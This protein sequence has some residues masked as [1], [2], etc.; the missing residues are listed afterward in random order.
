M[1]MFKL[2][3]LAIVAAICANTSSLTHAQNAWEGTVNANWADSGNWSTGLPGL[4]DDVVF[5]TP[6]P[7]T[8]SVITLG[9]G[10]L[11]NSLWIHDNYT[12]TGGDLALASGGFRVN[13]GHLLTLDSILSGANGLTLTG[14]GMVRL[15]NAANDYT[16]VTTIA[17]GSLIISDP[18]QLGADSSAVVVQGSATR[19]FG[20][21]QLVLDGGYGA[22]MDLSRDLVL[23]G[24]GPIADRS[25]ALIS[26]GNNTLSGAITYATGNVATAFNSANGLLTLSG[27]VTSAGTS[28]LLRFGVVN[29]AGVGSYHFTGKLFNHSTGGIEKLGSGTLILEPSALMLNGTVLVNSGSLRVSNGAALGTNAANG[30]VTLGGGSG[31]LEVRT[32]LPG[33]FASRRVQMGTSANAVLFLDHAGG[34]Q[35]LN[36]TVQFAPLTLTAGTTTRTLTINSRNGYGVTF[37]GDSVGGNLGGNNIIAINATGL[38]TFDGNFWNN[39][40]GTARTLTMTVNTGAQAVI[41]GNLIAS[42]SDHILTK[43]GAGTLTILGDASTYTGVTNVNAGTLAIS[44]FGSIN[45]SATHATNSRVNIGSSGTAA[46]LN[47]IG[48]DLTLAQASTGKTINLAGSAGGATILANQTGSSPGLIFNANF[49]ATGA[50]VKTLTLGG[51]NTLDNTIN[52]VIPNNSG[53]NITSVLKTGPG[54]WVLG[55]ANIYTGVT[56]ISNGTLKVRANAAAST[57][58]HDSSAITFGVTGTAAGGT[59]EFVGQDSVNNVENLGALSVSAGANTL[60]LTPGAGGTASL[61]FSSLGTV[62]GAASLNIL[63]SD[64]SN[65]VTLTGVADGLVSPMV[66]FDNS[67]F[68]Y[69][70]SEVLR[71]AV[72]GTD[73]GFLTTAG[74]ANELSSIAHWEMTGDVTQTGDTNFRSL[75]IVDSSLSGTNLRVNAEG[76]PGSTGATTHGTVISTGNSSIS[77]AALHSAGSGALVLNVVDGTLTLNTLVHGNSTGGLTKTGEGTLVI[78]GVNNQTG[79]TTINQGTVQLAPGGRLSANTQ[80]FVIRQGATLD[81]NGVNVSQTATTSSIGVFNGEGTIT[82]TSAASAI[83]A[84]AGTGG[85]FNGTI[86]EVN[87][88][89]SVIKMGTTTTQVFNGLSNYTGSTTI[90]V[91]GN[92]TTGT[93]SAFYLADIGQDSSIG[94]GDATDTASNAAS[95]VFGGTTGGLIYTGE[96]SLST[97]RLFTLAGTVAGAGATITNNGINNAALVFSN[98]NPIAFTGSANQLLRL[99]GSSLADNWFNPQITNGNDSAVTSFTKLGAGLWILG[100]ENNTYTGVTTI[101]EGHLQAQDGSSLP[102][103]SA[104]L[105]GGAATTTTSAV[106]QSSGL[107]TRDLGTG[108]GQVSWGTTLTTGGAGFAASTDKLVVAI[109]GLGTETPLVWNTGGFLPTGTGVGTALV[110]SSTTALAEVE[111]RNA[112]DLNGADRRIIVNDN[113]STFTDFATLSGVISGT[114]GLVKTNTAGTLRLLGEN[115]YSG[116]TTITGGTLIVTSLGN[117][118][119]PGPS[120]VG[121]SAN[122]NTTGSAVL[123]GGAGAQGILQ[124]VGPGETSDRMIRL[125]TTSTSNLI[126]ADGTGPLILTNVVND[127]TVNAKTLNLR[128]SSTA[129]NMITSNLTDNTG[130]LSVTVDG[131]ATWILSGNNTYTGN[132]TISGG[133]L[134]IGSDNAIGATLVFNNGSVFAYGGDRTI[135][136]ALSQSSGTGTGFIGDYSLTFTSSLVSAQNSTTGWVTS[137]NIVAGK[138]LTF[139]AGVTAN[140][141]TAARAWTING[142]GDTII[143]GDITTST[144]FGLNITYS[145]NGSLLLNGGN[146]TGGTF[147]INNAAGRVIITGDNAFGTGNALLTTGTL[148]SAGGDRVIANN[149]THGGTFIIGGDDK[150]TFTGTW[151]N[152]AGSR[153]LNVA[154]LGGVELAGNVNLSEH[155]TT[156][157]T[158]TI[159]GAGDVLISGVVSNGTGTGASALSYTGSGVMTLTGANTY[160]GTTTLNNANGVLRLDGA[161]LLGGGNVTLTNGLLEILDTGVDQSIGG[162]LT[163]GASTSTYAE[164]SIG[165]GRT[166]TLD[167][168]GAS[169]L[170]YTASNA[171]TANP[172]AAII[173]GAGTLDLGAADKTITVADNLSAVVDLSWQMGELTGASTSTLIKAGAGTLDISGIGLNSFAGIYQIDAGTILGLDTLS[174]N[175]ALNGGVYTGNGVF[176]RALGTGD[177]QIQWLAGGGGFAA[178]G[179]NLTVTLGGAPD[180]LVWDDTAGFAP[181]G[182]PLIFGSTSSDGVVDFTHNIDLNDAARTVNVVNNLASEDDKT[183]LSGELSGGSLVKT[184]NG[185]L[186]LT[187]AGNS[188][189]G[190]TLNGNGGALQFSVL[191]NL[192]GSS[193][194]IALQAG[195]LSFIGDASLTV[196]NV[197]DATTGTASQS[198]GVRTL[199]ANGTDGAI[200]T[201]SS[202]INTGLNT[203]TLAGSGTGVLSG[204]V[205]QTGNTTADIAITSGN[206]TIRDGNITVSDDLLVN[207]GTLTLEDMVFTLNDDVVATGLGTVLNLNTTGVLAAISPAGTSTGLYSRN[208]ALINLNA[209]DV[210]GADNSGGLD[211]ILLGDSGTATAAGTLNMNAFNLTTPRLDLGGYNAGLEGAILGSGTLTLTGVDA[212]WGTGAR[213]WRGVIEANLAGN[214]TLWKLGAG[215]VTLSGDNSGLTGAGVNTRVDGGTLIL[216]YTTSNTGKIAANVALDQRGGHVRLLGNESAGTTQT[217]NGLLLNAGSSRI[218]LE[219]G[220][221]QDLT[222][223]LGGIT[224]N[225]NGAIHFVLSAN[226]VIETSMPDMDFLGGWAAVNNGFAS[227][228]GGQIVA[229]ATVAKDDLSTWAE[230]DNLTDLNGYFGTVGTLAVS[231][232]AFESANAST[233]TIGASDVLSL[234]NGGILVAEGAGPGV[235]TGGVLSSDLRIGTTAARNLVIHQHNTA[236]DFTISSTIDPRAAITKA[237]AGTLVLSGFNDLASRQLY[238]GDGTVRALGGNAIGDLSLVTLSTSTGMNGVLD[239]SDAT[240]TIGSLAGGAA[241]G[242]GFGSVLLGATGTLTLNSYASPT[243]NAFLSGGPDSTLIKNKGG[244]W[245]TNSIATGFTGQVIINGGGIRLDGNTTAQD[246]LAQARAFTI[247]GPGS[248]LISDQDQSA[249]MN[250]ISDTAA[251]TLANTVSTVPIAAAHGLILVNTQDGARA[252]TVGAVTLQAGYNSIFSN[253]GGGTNAARIGTLTLT[254][255]TRQNRSTLL[256]GGQNLGA[257][258]G[259][260]GRITVTGGTLANLGGVGGAGV[261]GT[262]TMS[263]IPYAVGTAAVTATT[264]ANLYLVTGNSLVTY[265]ATNGFRPLNL[266][267]E[268]VL[269]EAGYNGLAASSTNNVRFAANPA[270]AL[271]GGSKTIN[272]LVLDSS[273]GALTI[274]S[275]AAG[276]LMLTSGA[277]LATT[278]AAANGIT[279]NGFSELRTGTAEYLI[280]VTTAAN[281]LTIDAALTSGAALTKSGPGILALTNAANSYSGGTWLNQGL[282][283][284]SDPAALGYG[285]INFEG[286]GL[287]WAPGATFD[288]STWGRPLNFN[289]GGAVFDSN[290][291]D[292]IL[293]GPTGNGGSGGLTKIGNGTLTLMSA[294]VVDF[295]GSVTVAGGITPSS[296]LVYGVANA[297]PSTTDLALGI[298]SAL[299]GYFTHGAFETTLRGLNINANSVIAGEADLTFTGR[300]EVHGGASRTLTINNTGTTTFDGDFLVLVDRGGTARTLTITAGTDIASDITINSE[301]TDGATIAG[302]LAFTT[303]N[304]IIRLNGFNTHTGA[305]TL[306]PGALGT[307]IL[308]NDQALGLGTANFT[309]GTLLS[310]GGDL[311]IANNITHNG[312]FIIGGD[313][314]FTFTGTWLNSTGSR[315]LNVQTLAGIELAGNVFL[316]EHA[317]TARTLTITGPGDV[318]IS[319]QV[320]NGIGTG[321]SVLAYTGTGTLTLGGTVANT[322]SNTTLNNA[323]G[324]L[325]LMNPNNGGI[326]TNLFTVTNGSLQVID[327]DRTIATNITWT[328]GNIIG[329]DNLTISALTGSTGNNRV[330]TNNLASGAVLTFDGNLNINAEAVS[331]TLTIAGSG[332]T[333]ISGVIQNGTATTGGLIVTSTGLTIISGDANTYTGATTLGSTEVDAGI[334]RVMPGSSLGAAANLTIFSGM[335]D[336]LTAP[337]ITSLTMGNGPLG[338]TSTL[339]LN[340]H[341]L[342]LGGNVTYTASLNSGLALVTPGELTLNATRT[343]TINKSAQT[344]V[345]MIIEADISDG[346]AA[347]GF[348]KSGNGTLTLKGANSFTGL[349]TINAGG[350]VLDFTASNTNKLSPT[351][352]LTMPGS[353]LTLIGNDAAGSSQTVTG[354]TL[355]AGASRIILEH[356]AGQTVTLTLGDITRATLSGAVDFAFTPGSG[357]IQTSATHEGSILGGWATVNGS[358]F[359][360]I[361]AGQIVGFASTAKDDI[362]TWAA[363]DD[364]TDSAGYFGALGGPLTINSLRIGTASTVDLGGS[365]LTVASGGI[366]ISPDVGAGA[367][368]ITG[369]FLTGTGGTG[370]ELFVHQH[371]TAA[372]FEIAAQLAGTGTLAKSGAGVLELSG[373]NTH[374]GITYISEGTLSVT[375]EHGIGKYSQVAFKNSI[376]DLNNGTVWT[377]GLG[378][379]TG[380]SAS[381]GTTQLGG[382]VLIGSGTLIVNAAGGSRTFTGALV[383]DGT[384]IKTGASVQILQGDSIPFTGNVIINGGQL[385]LDA[386]TGGINQAATITINAAELLNEQDQSGSRD[387]I[388][389][390]TVV[391]LNN[392]A[393]SA[394][395]AAN[396]R[397]LWMQTLNQNANRADTIGT[398]RLGAGHNVIQSTNAA[399]ATGTAQVATMTITNFERDNFATA[400]L[401]GQ[402]LGAATGSRGRITTPLA[403]FELMGAVGGAYVVGNTD[404]NIIPYFIGAAGVASTMAEADLLLQH[405]NSFVTWVSAGEGFRPLNLTTEY[406]LNEA[407]YN[408]LAGVTQHNV[409]FAANPAAALTGGSKTI[410]SLVL[411]SSAGALTITGDAGDT[412]T[413]ASGALMATTTVAA[414]GITLGGFDALQTAT[415]E[416]LIYVTNVANKLT[417]DSPLTSSASLTKAG[418]GILALTNAANSYDGGTWFNQGLIEVSTLDALGTGDLHF[419]GGGL[420]W[421]TGATFD[422]SATARALTFNSGGAVFDTNG[423][424]VAVANAIGNGGSGG[425]TKLGEGTLTLNAPVDFSGSVRIIGGATATSALVYGVADALPAGTDLVLGNATAGQFPALGGYFDHAGFETTLGGLNVNVNSVI[426]GTADLT[427]TGDVEFHGSGNRTLTINNTGTTTFNGDLFTL[428]DR[429]GTARTTTITAGS[430]I[431]SD[432]TINSQIVDGT[433]TGNLSFTANNGIIT[434]N[435]RNTY[436]GATTINPGALGTVVISNDQAFGLG[437]ALTLASGTLQGDGSGTKTLNQNVTN[438]TGTITIGG[439]DGFVFNGNWLTSGGTR[440]LVANTT[441]GVV[442]NGTITLGETTNNR[443]QVFSGSGDILINGVIQNNAGAGTPAGAITYTGTGTLTLTGA[444]TY[445]GLTQINGGVLA[446]SHDGALGGTANGTVVNPGGTLALSNDIT[447]T[448]ESLALTAGTDATGHATLY[449]ADGSNTWTGDLTVDTGTGDAR[450]I[451]LA[452]SGSALEISGNIAIAN[453]AANRDIVFAGGG[454]VEIS[455]SITSDSS[456]TR[457]RLFMSGS[458]FYD[459]Y[460]Q[461]GTLILSGDNSGYY[462]RI[463]NNSQGA[464]LQ[465]S[466]EANLGAVPAT[467][468]NN[469]LSLSGGILRT[470]AD[471]SISANRGVFL[472]P[473]G[474]YFNTDA[475]TTLTIHSIVNDA[476]SL[477][478]I[479]GGTLELTGANTYTGATTVQAGTLVLAG[480]NATSGVT[481]EDGGALHLA[482]TGSLVNG[483]TVEEG[484]SL[485][486]GGSIGGASSILGDHLIGGSL[487]QTFGNDLTYDGATVIWEL[488][489][490]L[491]TVGGIAVNNNLDFAG[492]TLLSLAFGAGVDFDDLFWKENRSWLIYEVAGLTSGFEN[493]ILDSVPLGLLF[494]LVLDDENIRLDFIYSYETHEVDLDFPEDGVFPIDNSVHSVAV[495]PDGKILVGGSFTG[496]LGTARLSRLNADGELDAAFNANIPALAS[497]SVDA[498]AVQA[499]GKILVAGSFPGNV[500]RLNAD[501]S[502]DAGFTAPAFDTAAGVY[503]IAIQPD[504]GILL[505]GEFET[506]SSQNLIRLD[507]TG[508]V[509]ASF[510]STG[511]NGEIR[512]ITL[513]RDGG[514]YVGGDFTELNGAPSEKVAKLTST[515]ATDAGFAPPALLAGTIHSLV[516]Q[517]DGKLLVAGL[518]ADTSGYLARL[519]AD[520]GTVDAAFAANLPAFDAAIN[521]IALQTDGSILVAGAFTG[522]LERLNVAGQA[523]EDVALFGITT[524]GEVNAITYQPDG[525][526]IVGGAFT[527]IG[528]Q[529]RERLARLQR[530]DLG[531]VVNSTLAISPGTGLHQVDFT[532]TR[533][534]FG[535]PE[536]EQVLFYSSDDNVTWTLVEAGVLTHTGPDAGSTTVWTLTDA[537]PQ[538]SNPVAYRVL[539]R[540]A[541]GALDEQTVG[542]TPVT[543]VELAGLNP[544][545]TGGSNAVTAVAKIGGTEV[546]VAGFSITYAKKIS[547]G[548]YDTPETEAPVNAGE[549]QVAA[550]IVDLVYEGGITTDGSLLN[551]HLVVEQA[552]QVIAFG[553]PGSKLTTDTV[554]LTATSSPSG[555]P[556]VFDVTGPVE[557]E[558]ETPPFVGLPEGTVLTFTGVGEVT[559]TARQEGDENY[560]AATPVA[561]AFNVS[562]ASIAITIGNLKQKFD[563][564]PK[565]VTVTTSPAG[566][567]HSITYD[568]GSTAPS[569]VGSYHVVVTI[570]EDGYIGSQTATLLIDPR[571]GNLE[572]PGE[573]WDLPDTEYDVWNDAFYAGK[574]DGLLHDEDTD[575]LVG[576]ISSVKVSKLGKKGVVLTGKARLKGRN[577]TL[578]GPVTPEGA[579]T[580]T[581]LVK[582]LGNLPVRVDLQ[583]GSVLVGGEP[584]AT[585]HVLKGALRWNYQADTDEADLTALAW[586]PKGPYTNKFP[587][588]QTG[589]YT[590][591]LPSQPGWGV[592][593][594]G[595]DGWGRLSIS[596]AGVVKLAGR[597]GDGVAVTETAYLSAGGE[598]HL[599]R[600][601]Y[602]SKPEKGRIGGR[603]VFGEHED[604]SDF[605]GE[606][607]WKKFN[608]G[609]EKLYPAGFQVGVNLIGSL[610]TP[611]PKGARV[612]TDSDL[613]ASGTATLSL[614]GPN[615]PP[616]ANNEYEIERTVNW[617]PNNKLIYGVKGSEMLKSAS[618]NPKTGLLKGTFTNPVTKLTVK[619]TGIVFQKQQLAAG[620]FV[621]NFGSGALRLVPNPVEETP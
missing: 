395:G 448:G 548:V 202:P 382:Q 556:V 330:L 214:S 102:A 96:T 32:D 426:T 46:T 129:G 172:N 109:G 185:I 313:D 481:V 93:L 58:I 266:T 157:R 29:S 539:S 175:I 198:V 363:G 443:T 497:G 254:S 371:N 299:G 508:A 251:I 49:M 578:R 78:A 14:G 452:Q 285:S 238:I 178:L 247:S 352:G 474:G 84:V 211:F 122:A 64:A 375:G 149:V 412:L 111:F 265:D 471:M 479:G 403:S 366:I 297:L 239:L 189:T 206:W 52:G 577:I 557:V 27:S 119:T 465:V 587:A 491:E 308:G 283:E 553:N 63:G 527:T 614:F 409:R 335:V 584:S 502:L 427:F 300:V 65:T 74:G 523:G 244:I 61:V 514:I 138:T 16:G 464:T 7:V 401:R 227:V 1:S 484:A 344:D 394:I 563:G 234:T 190:I 76:N 295:G 601:L 220:A 3:R 268:Y 605:H 457:P 92:G 579:F 233:V 338:S 66:F 142:S 85:V 372:P 592:S 417:I 103:A 493:F 131:G 506:G 618:I 36:Q 341:T 306:N 357:I 62:A 176:T 5:G 559:V 125:N 428:V 597:L 70:E 140:A 143:N 359:A 369:G 259:P 240:E 454:A 121:D 447:V 205:S 364:V 89:I 458:A 123:L 284:I 450:A 118:A 13:L 406:I 250:L 130:A 114:G 593:E 42:G 332:D 320:S 580:Q 75:R 41:T 574:Y 226:S 309:S 568:G 132:T 288:P 621:L 562:T 620:H 609:R 399:A 249:V 532:W 613:A 388:G 348:T 274:T 182:A 528:G 253:T 389:N 440:T 255:L 504:G 512:A 147:T 346:S 167:G 278:T 393:M 19:G 522:G 2:S 414:N 429:G 379:M 530:L 456:N 347:S 112:I 184:G 23:Q 531:P 181:D 358:Q 291:N 95:L 487:D 542:K 328:A 212:A 480:S 321:V 333:T 533:T 612:L 496:G 246:T 436:T 373:F 591:L 337:A 378:N 610:F 534:G 294:D 507:P 499:D 148:Q 276:T 418:N 367:A 105:L 162:L 68:A 153:T 137:N 380:A 204:G 196:D 210:Y 100:N 516:L 290:G 216:D 411:D 444:N 39:T 469:H 340:G 329:T 108:A 31:T 237:G 455:G 419:F 565:T 101:T 177:N 88:Q 8:G 416:Y 468:A 386:G 374:R 604:I 110:L 489:G 526:I 94:R 47:I 315:T 505:G 608:D 446:V 25:A 139:D 472:G 107:F 57:V 38:V 90:G 336:L 318:L 615:L 243:F 98:T 51:A 541:G 197:I 20:G 537:E 225:A 213:L 35:L 402:A 451:F 396:N 549:Y 310:A 482:G 199:A 555:L 547:E 201:F 594:P 500:L 159:T 599:Y 349:T 165:A 585:D 488:S 30:A 570:T 324:I 515:G 207:G 571:F 583:L 33:S 438:S 117:S 273:A 115:T 405:G 230:G 17:N 483:V 600:E 79:A 158:L 80:A 222:L 494:K 569:A 183:I 54:T 232:L 83:F 423:N 164:L 236:E 193:T 141:L 616:V 607:D 475:D 311:T 73:A 596:K 180:P 325:R 339:E 564:S 552:E 150:F 433:F 277:L 567:S 588:P 544:T 256:L 485:S 470:T 82:N 342:N 316:S 56:T 154:T 473:N 208:G 24:Y 160:G 323:N 44:G 560:L 59:L 397:G 566:L 217:V 163:L 87:G 317:T 582:P 510:T 413:L 461:G 524:D 270:A 511:T 390:N 22:G 603:V 169:H 106:F 361:E 91:P 60:R 136:N 370:L 263:V 420:R 280:H 6:A 368:S 490:Q 518:A 462:G 307:V 431:A 113:T 37:N 617:L 453:P 437:T 257:A 219:H 241:S 55:G 581:I 398:V 467:F 546:P 43:G 264:E 301:V 572:E 545:Y 194:P 281:T 146:T 191:G 351:A 407:G 304:G 551:P 77:G 228:V 449:N 314:K 459:S 11:A 400:L 45:N 127:T 350:L 235:I 441:G 410:N 4:A 203:L 267:S 327:G 331:R 619:F 128:G 269:N 573:G 558:G 492:P 376:L 9:A 392:T 282:I 120:S 334:L 529:S 302:T 415:S 460:G 442:I 104:L 40:A 322:H 486:G 34:G 495:Q 408:G 476:G 598:F 535:I 53:T 312:T 586:L 424:N 595:G 134:G 71:A 561:Q 161:G 275:G 385:H 319:G 126:H 589:K 262:T 229:A 298:H 258:A 271:T 289:A 292:V 69:A 209:N 116:A 353:R 124:Y 540:S 354:L 242:T 245:N 155:A 536:A 272:S 99:G 466:S 305:T 355:T 168:A 501:G 434:I 293:A 10:S 377:G 171:A 550:T 18:A 279:L 151:L 360:R 498:I 144:A 166:L 421:A 296:A 517:P 97:N 430:G 224:R 343:F 223:N 425:L 520:D 67:H 26:V 173:S 575:E 221:S 391:I 432:I 252:D 195:I 509:D 554:T 260:A 72:Y 12:F 521:R 381:N 384:F 404:I 439:A 261:A 28:G 287:R 519:D 133:A 326:G 345:E 186:Q 179:G 477:V 478:K 445:T 231:N 513:D 170:T 200:V 602:R 538:S 356:G 383:G 174:N 286:G 21:G 218:T 215:E 86:D 50:G 365:L 543:T 422:P 463:A 387:R 590:V 606:L 81:L 152:N 135:A 576:A 611:A 503:A 435:G 248:H 187:N 192:G 525:I 188:F 362:S 145:G 303:N 15:T 48:H 156:A